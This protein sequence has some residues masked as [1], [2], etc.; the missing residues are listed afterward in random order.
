MLVQIEKTPNPLSLKFIPEGLVSEEPIEINNLQDA[1]VSPLAVDLFKIDGVK[2][3][4]LASDFIAVTIDKETS[5]DYLKPQILAC[6]SDYYSNDLEIINYNELSKIKES[7]NQKKPAE[8][9]EAEIQELLEERIRPAV[10]MDG[11]DIVFKEFKDGIVYLRLMGACSGC[12]S[13]SI[14][15]KN[16]IENMLKYFIPEVK[17]VVAVEDE[18]TSI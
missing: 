1:R 17:E 16:G 5:W 6:I 18:D 3:I 4:F 15:L 13:S 7:N 9:V 10:A 12:P 8:G 14:T 2:K 11:G